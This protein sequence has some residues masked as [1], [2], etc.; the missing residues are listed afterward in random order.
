[1]RQTFTEELETEYG[2]WKGKRPSEEQAI[3]NITMQARKRAA[4]RAKQGWELIS[5]DFYPADR[6][7]G[8]PTVWKGR[9]TYERHLE[10]PAPQGA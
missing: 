1:M 7:P 6:S 4:L 9:A 3:D 10:D 5:I 8:P 2:K